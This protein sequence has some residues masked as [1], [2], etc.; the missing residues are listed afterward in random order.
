MHTQWTRL[1][2]RVQPG[3]WCWALTA[4]GVTAAR[5]LVVLRQAAPDPRVAPASADETA[6]P[7]RTSWSLL[8]QVRP[9]L[10]IH[11]PVHRTVQPHPH[12]HPHLELHV[13]THPPHLPTRP[14]AHVVLS[15][16]T[17]A[18]A[19]ELVSRSSPMFGYVQRHRPHPI[20]Q[21]SAEESALVASIT[22]QQLR[23]LSEGTP[24]SALL[25]PPKQPRARR[26]SVRAGGNTAEVPPAEATQPKEAHETEAL[27]ERL[28]NRLPTEDAAARPPRKR[29]GEL[30]MLASYSPKCKRGGAGRGGARATTCS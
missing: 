30:A 27:R 28:V 5:R 19:R 6:V 16:H 1:A 17:V 23:L 14:V 25:P 11:T 26:A 10:A 29:R 12:T 24:L 22:E 9:S 13:P 20:P 3:E 21:L 2:P 7:H 18:V 8:Q 4:A 15:Q